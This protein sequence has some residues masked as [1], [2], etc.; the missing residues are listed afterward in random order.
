MHIFP[1]LR[2]ALRHNHVGFATRLLTEHRVD[3]F[4][5]ASA[6]VSYDD[7]TSLGFV[8]DAIPGM[9][10]ERLAA[11]SASQMA[12][13]CLRLLL[14]NKA[15]WPPYSLLHPTKENRLDMLELVLQHSRQWCPKVPT[16]AACLGH[17]RFLMRIFDAGCPMWTRASDDQEACKMI[18]GSR[19]I[20]KFHLWQRD[21]ET[22]LDF[23]LMV[24]SDL[25]VS[26][27]VLLYAAQKGAPLTPRM[28]MRLWVVR[29]RALALAGCFHRAARL[30]RGPGPHAR[31]W[32]AMGQVPPE[33]VERI[34]TLARISIRAVDLVA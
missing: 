4:A 25:V 18:P 14:E 26:G 22:R 27:P 9:L 1:C 6:C 7:P 8:V 21:A 10:L 17:T 3:R 32:V 24:S 33:I 31:K 20:E 16:L 12:I 15:P 2:L 23:C 29:L 34:A 19:I 11:M 30:G 28:E 13:N 5:F